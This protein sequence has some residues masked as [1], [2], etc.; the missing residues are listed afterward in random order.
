MALP[1]TVDLPLAWIPENS[2]L[3]EVDLHQRV[4]TEEDDSTVGVDI[5]PPL[6]PGMI[7]E[8]D[9]CSGWS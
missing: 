4:M 1:A 3:T 5:P 6:P 9:S 7:P 8:N 2:L